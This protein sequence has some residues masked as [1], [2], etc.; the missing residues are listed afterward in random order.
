MFLGQY[1]HTV[2]GKGRLVLPARYRDRLVNGCVVT[3]GQE[4]CLYVFPMDRWEEEVA[5]YRNL[6]RTDARAR[7]LA[8]AFFAGAI[9][10][11]LDAAGR[12]QLPS[13]LREYADLGKQVTVIGV[14]DRAEIWNTEA[15]EQYDEQAD[16]FYSSIEEA[17]SDYGV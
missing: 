15:W 17:L 14:E 11:Q 9:R 8:R 13:R 6:S 1:Q 7:R 16:E 5:K 4:R 10:Q 2:D 3:K 12:V